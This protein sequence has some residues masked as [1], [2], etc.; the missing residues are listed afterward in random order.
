M[1]H[2]LSGGEI[3]GGADKA[4]PSL[5]ERAI[6]SDL[7]DASGDL[8]T[9]QERHPRKGEIHESALTNEPLRHLLIE[10]IGRLV[11]RHPGTEQRPQAHAGHRVDGN[12]QLPQCAPGPKMG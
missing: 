10:I 11:E 8:P 12:L 4:P 3:A 7:L 6:A 2:Q 1:L 5:F 9:L